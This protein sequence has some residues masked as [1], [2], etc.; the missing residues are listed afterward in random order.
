MTAPA[1]PHVP[2]PAGARCSDTWQADHPQPYR[3]IEG[4][5]RKITDHRLTVPRRE[6]SKG[7]PLNYCGGL[8]STAHSQAICL[9]IRNRS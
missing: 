7:A 8:T 3:I 9:L 1:V 6:D 2:L 5:G 4:T